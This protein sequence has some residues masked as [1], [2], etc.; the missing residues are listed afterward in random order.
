M[1]HLL[2]PVLALVML[3]GGTSCSLNFGGSNGSKSYTSTIS[4]KQGDVLVVEV[5]PSFD[6]PVRYRG[7]TFIRIGPRRD[8]ATLDEERILSERCSSS[9]PTFDTRPC[10]EA[11]IDDIHTNIIASACHSVLHFKQY[12]IKPGYHARAWILS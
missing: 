10:R 9:L 6:T 5:T 2:I 8:I 4:G 11:T 3:M 12:V 1:R 7:R